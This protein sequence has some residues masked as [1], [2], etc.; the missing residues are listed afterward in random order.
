MKKSEETQK[1]DSEI[2]STTTEN[3]EPVDWDVIDF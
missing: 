3:I 1:T 2:T